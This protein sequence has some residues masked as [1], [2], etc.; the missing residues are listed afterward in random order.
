MQCHL[1]KPVQSVQIH[2]AWHIFEGHSQLVLELVNLQLLVS[3]DETLLSLDCHKFV[4][5]LR[6]T[7]LYSVVWLGSPR[8]ILDIQLNDCL[9]GS[10]LKIIINFLLQVL[11]SL[12]VLFCWLFLFCVLRKVARLDCGWG[13]D[14]SLSFLYRRMPRSVYTGSQA[15]HRFHIHCGNEQVRWVLMVG[16]SIRTRTRRKQA[17]VPVKTRVLAVLSGVP[18]DAL[19]L[20]GCQ[21]VGRKAGTSR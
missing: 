8:L 21:S 14:K 5:K 17:S 15:S 13:Y 9:F 7:I 12:F 3:Q 2:S 16:I 20:V 1:L 4:L 19:Q 10:S 11:V 18:T 6:F